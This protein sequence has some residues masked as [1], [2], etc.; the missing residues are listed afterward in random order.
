[1]N[2]NGLCGDPTCAARVEMQLI[3]A[4]DKEITPPCEQCA[5]AATAALTAEQED[6]LRTMQLTDCHI[7]GPL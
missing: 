6:L 2:L 4:D 7:V 3:F 1:M 5:A